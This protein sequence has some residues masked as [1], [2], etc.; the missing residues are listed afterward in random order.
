[1]GFASGE[2]RRGAWEGA[3]EAQRVVWGEGCRESGVRALERAPCPSVSSGLPAL[4][5]RGRGSWRLGEHRL[6]ARPWKETEATVAR[7][8]SPAWAQ[9]SGCVQRGATSEMLRTYTVN[10]Q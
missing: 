8:S 5:P 10:T 3:T 7:E 6:G 1:M 4:H 9:G 2:D